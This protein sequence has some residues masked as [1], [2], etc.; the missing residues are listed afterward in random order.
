M[1]EDWMSSR[2]LK[3]QFSRFMLFLAI[4]GRISRAAHAQI[5][6]VGRT[7]KAAARDGRR[8]INFNRTIQVKIDNVP[9]D[10][11]DR[12]QL[13]ARRYHARRSLHPWRLQGRI[14]AEH[15]NRLST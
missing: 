15:Q 8:L 9:L 4:A 3:E 14:T 2:K 10:L 6:P 11:D 13:V 1:K 12:I 5:P 7:S